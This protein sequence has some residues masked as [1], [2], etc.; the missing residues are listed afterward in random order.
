MTQRAD[1]ET[2]IVVRKLGPVVVVRHTTELGRDQLT[3]SIED[4]QA[5]MQQLAEVLA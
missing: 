1:T 3:M 2:E 4:A 5:L